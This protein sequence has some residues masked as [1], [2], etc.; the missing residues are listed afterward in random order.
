[1]IIN[2]RRAQ[3][4][5]NRLYMRNLDRL[6]EETRAQAAT[7]TAK[8][9]KTP[10]KVQRREWVNQGLALNTLDTLG[11]LS[12]FLVRVPSGKEIAAERILDDDGQIA[13]VPCERKFA[14]A[15]RTVKRRQ[16]LRFPLIPGYILVGLPRGEARPDLGIDGHDWGRLFRFKIVGQVVGHEGR[17]VRVPFGQI[18][19]LL[20]RQYD[21]KTAST[22][23]EGGR[24]QILEGPF[25][26]HVSEIR[27]IK[28][29]MATMILNLFG[30]DREV[31]V[32]LTQLGR[33]A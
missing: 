10:R 9:R 17:P 24:A 28:G 14:R 15:N 12:W 22:I 5:P 20:R 23:E 1:M 18:V 29:G 30:C 8:P 25:E 11:A 13:F 33:A 27:A 16:E 19:P 4:R 32:A 21:F 2:R 7:K 31:E 6:V 26:G 3:R